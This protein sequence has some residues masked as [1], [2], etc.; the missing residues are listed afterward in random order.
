M[1]IFSDSLKHYIERNNI[2]VLPLARYC[3]IERSTVYKFITGKRLPHSLE[4]V[5]KM[6]QF[7]RLSPLET[8]KLKKCMENRIYWTRYLLFQK[9]C[10]RFYLSFS[11]QTI[12]SIASPFYICIRQCKTRL[13]CSVFSTIYR[14]LCASDNFS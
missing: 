6:A 1:S 7:M 11:L 10:R 8:E 4:L 3:D 14:Q 2:R 12:F 5:E 13:Y 9:K